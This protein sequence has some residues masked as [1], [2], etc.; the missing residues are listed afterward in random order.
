MRPIWPI[1][2]R[3]TLFQNL[4]LVFHRHLSWF[5]IPAFGDNPGR[6]LHGA[7]FV[8]VGKQTAS[9]CISRGE[10]EAI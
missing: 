1:Y 6:A 2:P 4:I 9:R 3:F 10:R 8:R 5:I 7:V